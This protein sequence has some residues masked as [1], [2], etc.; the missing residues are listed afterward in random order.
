MLTYPQIDKNQ[1]N[2]WKQ[3]SSP[4][5]GTVANYIPIKTDWTKHANGIRKHGSSSVY[6]CDSGSTWYAAI[7]QKGYWEQSTDKWIP[8][9]N[10]Q[11]TKETELWIRIDNLTNDQF[12]KLF[13]NQY[14]QAYAIQ[15]I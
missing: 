14:L 12:I 4:E 11:S 10:E 6:N 3:T 13:N 2:R 9:A 15:E 8:A 1:Y 5:N 7:G